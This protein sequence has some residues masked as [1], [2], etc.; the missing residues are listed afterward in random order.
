V[1]ICPEDEPEDDDPVTWE[2]IQSFDADG[3]TATMEPRGVVVVGLDAN[4]YSSASQHVVA[5]TLLGEAADVR[6]TPVEWGWNYGD[7]D[8]RSTSTAGASW[9]QLD[10]DEFTPTDTS[11]VYENAGDYTVRTRV[12]FTAEYRFAGGAWVPLGGSITIPVDALDVHVA[13]ARTVLVS[14]PCTADPDGPGC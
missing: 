6:F 1:T 13:G 14:E 4:L 8:E 9:D 11:H 7:G 5:G 10:Q 3:G 12:A 2:D